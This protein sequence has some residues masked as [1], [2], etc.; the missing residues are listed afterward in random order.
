MSVPKQ[1]TV[2]FSV[3]LLSVFYQVSLTLQLFYIQTHFLL[4]YFK[5]P[6]LLATHR[7]SGKSQTSSI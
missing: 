6:S 7:T 2:N 4:R 1:Y 3:S 5:Q